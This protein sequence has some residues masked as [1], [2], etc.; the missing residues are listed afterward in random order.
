M[1]GFNSV[2]LHRD[3]QRKQDDFGSPREEIVALVAKR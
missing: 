3:Y 2:E 1:V